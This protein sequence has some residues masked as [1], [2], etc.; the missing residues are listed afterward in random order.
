MLFRSATVY[1]SGETLTNTV[2]DIIQPIGVA[3]PG[4]K[5]LS[6]PGTEQF[7]LA[8]ETHETVSGSFNTQMALPDSNMRLPSLYV[9]QREAAYD[10]GDGALGEIGTPG[11]TATA[12][13][14]FKRASLTTPEEIASNIG[15][16]GVL[17]CETAKMRYVANIA[18]DTPAGVY[19]TK[20]NYLAAPQY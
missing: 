17:T 18:A 4:T 8:F 3:T 14:A 20:V 5:T 13:F 7:G 2:G 19:T 11:V 1:Y 15:T 12:S 16:G 10:A 9:L 6:Q